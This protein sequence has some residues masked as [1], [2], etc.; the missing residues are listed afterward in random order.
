MPRQTETG[1]QPTGRR[2]RADKHF[3][4]ARLLAAIEALPA[5]FSLYNAD[6]RLALFNQRYREF[7][8]RHA[9]TLV[10]GKT[11]EE[12]LRAGVERGEFADAIG[13]EEEWIAER[14]RSH[15]D[16]QGPIEQRL[17]NGRWLQIEERRTGDG[18]TVGLRTDITDLKILE[19]ALKQNEG[20]LRDLAEASADWFWEMDADLRFTY[21]TQ[22]IE[23]IVGD[24]PE[25]YYGKSREDLLADDYDREAWGRHLQTL[26]DRKPFRNFEYLRVGEGLEPRW[27]CASG[28]PRFAGD[29]AF[30]G[31]RG[32]GTDVTEKKRAEEK[33]HASEIRLLHAQKMESIGRLT[34][35]IAHDFNNLLAVIQ[36]NLELIEEQVSGDEL[37]SMIGSALRSVARGAKLTGQLLM[38]GRKALLAPEVVDLNRSVIA[39][40]ELIRRT[41]PATIEIETGLAEGLWPAELDQNQLEAALLNIVLNARDAMPEGG[42][43]TIATA[44]IDLAKDDLARFAA[45]FAPGRYVTITASDT[46]HGMDAGTLARAFEPFFTTKPVGQG[47]GLGLSMVHG[48]ARHSGGDV[49]IDSAPGH[50]TTVRLYFPACRRDAV[51]D[52]PAPELAL[53]RAAGRECVLVVEDQ[54]DVRRVV[55]AQLDSLGYRVIEAEDGASALA[56]LTSGS[57][58]DILL[59]DLVMPG[60]PQGPAL[61]EQAR[62]LRP[63]IGVILMTGNPSEVVADGVVAAPGD[64]CLIKPI[65]KGELARE[66]WKQ[67]DDRGSE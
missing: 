2:T 60:K 63:G 29:G 26:R 67:L 22:N 45:G 42:R 10:A 47:S 20:R 59:T 27:L 64:V 40:G 54:A 17:T 39:M 28:V 46:G 4:N 13:R 44:N 30:L 58:V 57:R 36:G 48:F 18:E 33:L 61:A 66:V 19:Q 24:S 23:R 8:P 34:G 50:G 38:F 21:L 62:I 12:N 5:G 9:D 6:D 52:A 49:L 51:P 37:K 35:G 65:S 14:L 32:T 3:S 53:P 25:W 11:F 15:A 41:V 43:L 16:P 7:Y 56:A 55:A 31:Y 1:R